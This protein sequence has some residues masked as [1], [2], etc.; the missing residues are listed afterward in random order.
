MR[1]IYNG[2]SARIYFCKYFFKMHKPLASLINGKREKNQ[3][4][5][6]KIKKVIVPQIF[7][8]D[9]DKTIDQMI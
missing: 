8:F 5:A 7:I 4:Y 6:N 9:C 3:E 2:F 1:D